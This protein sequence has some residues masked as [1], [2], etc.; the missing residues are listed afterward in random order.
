MKN[1]IIAHV[2][3]SEVTLMILYICQLF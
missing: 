1:M 2:Y 3:N